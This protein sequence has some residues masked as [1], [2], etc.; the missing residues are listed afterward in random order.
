MIYCSRKSSLQQSVNSV[1]EAY[2]QLIME[3]LIRVTL[4]SHGEIDS[5]INQDGYYQTKP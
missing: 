3:N 1:W 5:K 4:C 2:V